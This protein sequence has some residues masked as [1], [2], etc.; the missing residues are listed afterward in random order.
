[1]HRYSVVPVC[2]Q[3]GTGIAE[4]AVRES[5]K[6]L[7]YHGLCMRLI[8]WRN[9]AESERLVEALLKWSM[10]SGCQQQESPSF[11]TGRMSIK[12]YLECL[13]L[14]G[15]WLIKGIWILVGSVVVQ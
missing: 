8:Q 5:E 6:K 15:C 12:R 7:G 14:I 1:M 2:L 9:S 13:F 11:R 3:Q 4:G 10:P